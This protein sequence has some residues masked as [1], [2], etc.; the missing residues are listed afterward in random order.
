MMLKRCDR[1]Q[2]EVEAE[3]LREYAG[4]QLCEDC[5]LEAISPVRACDPWAVHTA[6]STLATQGQQLT[7]P[8][9]KLYDLVRDAL[10]ISLS[11]AAEQLGLSEN[12][13]RREFATLR[14]MELLRAQPRPQGIVL[15]LF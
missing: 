6:K 10:E 4:Q 8:Q 9:Q 2:A 13:L 3:E 14:H 15:T 11:E 12:E 7:P 5:Y 1:C